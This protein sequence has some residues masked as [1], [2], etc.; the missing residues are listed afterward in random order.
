MT[1]TIVEAYKVVYVEPETRR[2]F[3]SCT[4][5]A[6]LYSDDGAARLRALY[7]G[8]DMIPFQPVPY[9]TQYWTK[10]PSDKRV[11]R[12][13]FAFKKSPGGLRHA[14]R[15]V[16]DTPG[17]TIMLA[18][19]VLYE[20]KNPDVIEAWRMALPT[21]LYSYAEI[22]TAIRLTGA[23][24]PKDNALGQEV[25]ADMRPAPRAFAKFMRKGP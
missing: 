24:N 22:C 6:T 8:N 18:E 12:P 4:K 2:A 13:I 9:S 17:T 25:A 7:I 16:A 19:V 23:F 14:E 21:G 3:S 20:H 11:V 15:A 10:A 5:L 1:P